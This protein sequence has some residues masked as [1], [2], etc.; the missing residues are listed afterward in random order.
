M[1]EILQF[2]RAVGGAGGVSSPFISSTHLSCQISRCADGGP[3][4]PL[5]EGGRL[6][7]PHFLS[8]LTFCLG[9]ESAELIEDDR[10]IEGKTRRRPEANPPPCRGIRCFQQSRRSVSAEKEAGPPIDEV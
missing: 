1:E 5:T 6:A 4:S 2:V 7:R 8:L 3:V 10:G 9:G